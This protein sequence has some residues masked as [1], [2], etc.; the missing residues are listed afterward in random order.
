MVGDLGSSREE[1]PQDRIWKRVHRRVREDGDKHAAFRIIEN[2]RHNERHGG[3]PEDEKG[4]VL[5]GGYGPLATKPD[6]Q[7]P[8]CP[9]DSKDE[10]RCHGP[11]ALL[12]V[13]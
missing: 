6:G 1:W 2:P 11:V 4:Y 7:V 12:E 3:D 8:K 5:D 9:K 13:R 10:T